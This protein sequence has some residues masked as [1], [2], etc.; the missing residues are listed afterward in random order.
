MENLFSYGTLQLER[1]QLELFGRTLKA[2]HDAL[3]GYKKEKIKIKVESV[4]NLSGEEEHVVISYTGNGSD[5][6]EG[7]VLSVAHDELAKAD[8]YETDDYK[9]TKVTLRSG[10]SAWVYIKNRK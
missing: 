2:E 7:A 8:E 1:V 9:R 6:V 5:V 4:V 3:I 10:K